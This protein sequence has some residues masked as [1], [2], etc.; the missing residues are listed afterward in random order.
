MERTEG[1]LLLPERKILIYIAFI[2]GLFFIK[3]L[4]FA[5]GIFILMAIL[6]ARIPMS[7]LKQGWI[8]ITIFLFFTFFS[9]LLFQ[10]GRILFQAGPLFVTEEGLTAALLRTIRIF[11]MIAGAKMLTATTGIEPLIGAFAG[12]LKPFE[13]LGVPVEEF[14]ST[15]GL[16]MKSLP[17][18]KE[19]VVREYRITVKDRKITGFR[20]RAKVIAS[21]LMPLFVQSIRSPETFLNEGVNNEAPMQHNKGECEDFSP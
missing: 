13:R 17:R 12:L 11:C 20:N 4:L 6:L 3:N 16:T 8:P 14:F 1:N 5:F 19:Q 15:M 10:H 2:L 18:L 9:N 21:F 7:S